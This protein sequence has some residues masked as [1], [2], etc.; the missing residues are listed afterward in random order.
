[1]KRIREEADGPVVLL[2]AGDIFQGSAFSNMLAGRP[3]IDLMNGLGYS[4]AVLGNHEFDWGVDVLTE[5]IAEASF[6]FLGANVIER[7]TGDLPPWLRSHTIID[8]GAIRLAVIGLISES[9][10]LTTLPSNVEP[11]DFPSASAAAQMWI[12][13]LVPD[14][15]DVAILLVHIG[16]R[17]NDRGGL[18]GPIAELASE[19]RGEAAILGGH[20]HSLFAEKVGSTPVVM[21]GSLMRAI[22]RVDLYWDT[23]ERRIVS[24]DATILR[25]SENPL[26]PDLETQAAVDRSREELGP[27]LGRVLGSAPHPIGRGSEG[28][29]IGNLFCDAIRTSLGI[30]IFL[31]NTGGIR[32]SLPAGDITYAMVYKVMP[33]DNTV[34]TI[35]M[36]GAEIH[37]VLV[38]AAQAACRL[39]VS[40]LSCVVDFRTPGGPFVEDLR[41]G[42]GRPI[43]RER[44]YSV[45]INSF[46]A[47]GGDGLTLLK[48]FPGSIDTG[49][50]CRDIFAR[51]IEEETKAGRKILASGDE[52]TRTVR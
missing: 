27:L 49:L 51:Y 3:L 42:K 16:G 14:S 19:V 22:A 25:F 20:S 11:Y 32:A 8:L 15:A 43:E 24:S 17:S 29:A 33:F 21:A 40:G 37:T 23:V 39:H 7:A 47:E 26:P 48:D 5:R 41:D 36:T 28:S 31:N 52:R 46:M 34:V 10:P 2:D 45:G 35:P 13:R 1:M 50:F 30:N 9:T 4:A 38:E 18:R 12:D 44:V 6:P